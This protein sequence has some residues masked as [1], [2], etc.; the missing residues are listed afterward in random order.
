MASQPIVQ[1]NYIIYF[2]IRG[3]VFNNIQGLFILNI[4]YED[5][6]TCPLTKYYYIIERVYFIYRL[7]ILFIST[8]SFLLFLYTVSWRYKRDYLH[9]SI[10][11]LFYIM[12]YVINMMKKH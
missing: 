12:F 8:F 7:F 6:T 4:G 9:A 1:W 2:R 11:I 5:M 10:D 3:S